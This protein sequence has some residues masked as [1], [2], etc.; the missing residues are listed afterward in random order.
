MFF[1][2]ATPGD[3]IEKL[4]ALIVYEPA[5][6]LIPLLEERERDLYGKSPEMVENITRLE[7][8]KKAMIT[9]QQDLRSAKHDLFAIAME[10]DTTAD[11]CR[12]HI[13][14]F[15]IT[16]QLVITIKADINRLITQSS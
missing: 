14:R 15:K 7:A 3:V 10:P 2:P 8:L 12:R 5:S 16:N 9:A 1:I 11:D 13:Q 6:I 4:A